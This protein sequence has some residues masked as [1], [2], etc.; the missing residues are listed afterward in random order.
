MRID[1]T[2]PRVI[3]CGFSLEFGMHVYA[4]MYK[5]SLFV[6]IRPITLLFILIP[7]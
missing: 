7:Y 5:I 4:K 1:L 2:G 3:L 6:F